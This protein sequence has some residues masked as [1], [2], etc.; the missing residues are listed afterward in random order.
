[1]TTVSMVA[2][3]TPLALA[4]DP[5]STAQ[6]SLGTVVIGGLLSSLLLTLVLVPVV[7]MWLAPGPPKPKAASSPT[8]ASETTTRLA[9]ESR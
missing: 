7:Y 3:M 6:R 2:G 8:P 9:L 5:G 4:L 1:M